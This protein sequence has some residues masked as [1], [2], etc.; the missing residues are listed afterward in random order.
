MN[1][2]KNNNN[3]QQFVAVEASKKSN[4][5]ILFDNISSCIFDISMHEYIFTR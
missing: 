2:E 4:K 5:H 1:N 3:L